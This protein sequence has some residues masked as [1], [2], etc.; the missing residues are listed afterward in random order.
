M[1]PVLPPAPPHHHR[2]PTPPAPSVFI[3]SP[4]F[5]PSPALIWLFGFS[6]LNTALH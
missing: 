6:S 1:V 2:P 3:P 5:P 4:A